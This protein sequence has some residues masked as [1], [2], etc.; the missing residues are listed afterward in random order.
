MKRRTGRYA[1]IDEREECD[2]RTTPI[3]FLHKNGI[4]FSLII[5]TTIS[6]LLLISD[7]RR[8]FVSGHF[9]ATLS[10]Y[11]ASVQIA[12]QLISALFGFLQQ[13]VICDLFNYE[14]RLRLRK[15]AVTV[16]AIYAWTSI[17][18]ARA[19]WDLRA[20][21]CLPT[22]AFAFGTLVPA[23]LWAGAITPTLI[24]IEAPKLGSVQIP[25]FQNF[26]TSGNGPARSAAVDLFL[27]P[28]RVSSAF[29]LA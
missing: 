20:K 2:R 24:V 12:V 9:Y 27:E 1:E 5:T 13:S 28:Q 29:L 8:W 19:A 16:D 3:V 14:T 22:V 23:A 25:Q 15:R 17:C 11:R 6:S 10:S 26:P 7:R 18:A 21:L 4:F